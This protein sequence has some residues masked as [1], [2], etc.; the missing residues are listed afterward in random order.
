MPLLRA[1]G[2]PNGDQH[3]TK[4]KNTKKTQYL[5][6]IHFC[7]LTKTPFPFTQIIQVQVVRLR[8]WVYWCRSTLLI[9][10]NLKLSAVSKLYR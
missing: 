5:S 2:V 1:H 6:I 7:D 9:C 4:K 3:G 10:Y 8:E